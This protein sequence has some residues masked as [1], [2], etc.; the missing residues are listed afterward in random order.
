M[1][2]DGFLTKSE[3][4]QFKKIVLEDYGVELTDEEALEQAIPLVTFFEAVFK[5]LLKERMR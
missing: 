1:D 2:N 4:E 5:D 3:L